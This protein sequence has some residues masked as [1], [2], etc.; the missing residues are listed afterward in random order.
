MKKFL[1]FI[2]V[3]Y[4]AA[5]IMF[6]NKVHVSIAWGP[7]C[8]FTCIYAYLNKDYKQSWVFGI[9]AVILLARFLFLN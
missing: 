3:L 9:G 1:L 4:I 6:L 5:M 7:F 2:I 8:V